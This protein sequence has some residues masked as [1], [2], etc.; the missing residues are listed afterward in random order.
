[1]ALLRHDPHHPPL[2]GATAAERNAYDAVLEA[3]EAGAPAV[4]AGGRHRAMSTRLP[5]PSPRAGLADWFTHSTGHSLGL[6]IHRAAP[7]RKENGEAQS[8]N[9]RYN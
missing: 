9:D 3:Q 1:M 5:A 2:A 8:R 7:R 6:E 4:R